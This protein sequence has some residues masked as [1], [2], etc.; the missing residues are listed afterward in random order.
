MEITEP[1]DLLDYLNTKYLAFHNIVFLQGIFLDS[2]AP[3][4]YDQCLRYGKTR[5]EKIMFFE[6]RILETGKF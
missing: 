4:L 2:K 6:K 5:A 1:L 3:K